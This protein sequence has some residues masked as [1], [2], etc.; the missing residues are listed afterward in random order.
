M[1]GLGSHF[2][3]FVAAIRTGRKSGNPFETAGFVAETAVLGA[4]ALRHPGVRL[5]WDRAAMRFTNSD[6]ATAMVRP[7]Y[8]EGY[9][10]V[11]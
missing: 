7:E 2:E 10:L 11:V 8:R 3:G 4:I 5:E 6:A 1:S 9:A